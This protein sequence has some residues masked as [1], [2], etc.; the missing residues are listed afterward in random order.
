MA[1]IAEYIW[2]EL[3]VDVNAY[4]FLKKLISLWICFVLF[5]TLFISG[6][7]GGLLVNKLICM[8]ISSKSDTYCLTFTSAVVSNK[9][10]ACRDSCNI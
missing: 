4:V 7:L 8:S 9:Q 6:L 1:K 10:K 2:P 5:W 3:V